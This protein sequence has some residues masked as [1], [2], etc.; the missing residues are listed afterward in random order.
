MTTI[1]TTNVLS[2]V[3]ELF[4]EA[5]EG[6][7]GPATWFVNNEPNC[8]IFGS[9]ESLSASDAS[10]ATIDGGRSL[11][12]HVEHL[13]WWLANVNS[14]ARGGAWNPDWSGSWSV[15][16]VSDDEWK[17]LRDAL[18]ME[19]QRVLD[20]LAEVN[21]TPDDRMMLTGMMAMSAHAAHHLGTMRQIV[22]CLR[23]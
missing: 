23:T 17:T 18:R 16:I 22:K 21:I 4:T 14:V 8:G 20:S 15:Q 19:Y 9:I 6:A 1:P 13:R 10:R 5:F 2:I 11:A 3:R 12:A 7:N